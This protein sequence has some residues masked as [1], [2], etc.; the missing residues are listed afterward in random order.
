MKLNILIARAWRADMRRL[1]L[2]ARML[3][4]PENTRYAGY[5]FTERTESAAFNIRHAI[6]RREFAQRAEKELYDSR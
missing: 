6:S 3:I 2:E 4:H 5:S 1:A